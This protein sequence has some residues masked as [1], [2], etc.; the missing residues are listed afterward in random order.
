MGRGSLLC[1]LLVCAVVI[2]WEHRVAAQDPTPTPPFDCVVPNG[3]H[4]TCQNKQLFA[5]PVANP[6]TEGECII[7]PCSG[8]VCSCEF[9]GSPTAL[10]QI[11]PVEVFVA[12][13]V[14]PGGSTA[15]CS[16][17]SVMVPYPLWASV[18]N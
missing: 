7:A 13:D 17:V 15:P 2:A 4:C 8:I 9:D 18:P 5:C 1:A 16:L 12:G 11:E 6:E 3:T 14:P 10:C